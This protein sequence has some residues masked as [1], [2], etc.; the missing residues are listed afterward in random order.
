VSGTNPIRKL[1]RVQVVLLIVALGVAFAAP[2]TLL[3]QQ[4]WNR[5]LSIIVAIDV[6]L[7]SLAI[8]SKT[9]IAIQLIERSR[10]NPLI[11]NAIEAVGRLVSSLLLASLITLTTIPIALLFYTGQDTPNWFSTITASIFVLGLY[12]LDRRAS[13]R[14]QEAREQREQREAET[15]KRFVDV[16]DNISR[17]LAVAPDQRATSFSQTVSDSLYRR[18]HTLL[19][20][21]RNLWSQ[22]KV[23]HAMRVHGRLGLDIRSIGLSMINLAAEAETVLPADIVQQIKEAGFDLR[24]LG[25][26]RGY[27]GDGDA[28]TSAGETVYTKSEQLRLRIAERLTPRFT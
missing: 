21:F 11:D 1:N 17:A 25:E 24:G 4:G 28:F 18:C 14:E 15:T 10:K 16:I 2:L 19:A 7:C 5:P 6:E 9:E 20:K 3:D 26:W 22:Y 13:K 8:A 12:F 23:D 27:L